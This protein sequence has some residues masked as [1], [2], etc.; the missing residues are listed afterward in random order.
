MMKLTVGQLHGNHV[1]ESEF[2]AP[3]H[4]S[5]YGRE[6]P[7]KNDY[8]IDLPGRSARRMHTDFNQNSGDLYGSTSQ[9]SV[10]LRITVRNL[11]S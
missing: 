5:L 1:V 9:E 4:R 6:K 2:Y 10:M 8:E 3:D 7:R 11:K